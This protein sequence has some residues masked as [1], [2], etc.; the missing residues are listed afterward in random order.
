MNS[1]ESQLIET[2]PKYLSVV[3]ENA[4]KET[5]LAEKEAKITELS[6][7]IA[8]LESNLKTLQKL[9]FGPKSEKRRD[10]SESKQLWLFSEEQLKLPKSDSPAVEVEI[11]V[12]AHKRKARKSFKDNKGNLSHFPEELARKE[13]VLDPEG[14]KSC[15]SCGKD[16]KEI[17]QVVTEKL[18]VVPCQYYVERIIR[19][20]LGCS[21]KNCPPTKAAS[22]EGVLPKSVLGLS[23]IGLSLTQK[24]AWHLPFYRQ[25]QMLAQVGIDVH[26]NMLVYMALKV[27]LE[28]KPI[29]QQMAKEI[30]EAELVHIDETPCIVGIRD[31]DGKKV[32]DRQSYFWPILAN[33]MVVFYYQG[34]RQHCNVKEILG[35]GFKGILMSDGYD[36]YIQYA[37]ERQVT[38]VL[39]W[40]HARRYFVK[41]EKEEPL[42]QEALDKIAHFYRV[43]AE[44]KKKLESH[45]LKPENISQYRKEHTLEQLNAFKD[46]CQKIRDTASVLPKSGLLKAVS[47]VVNHWEWLT[48]YLEHGIV[49]ISNVKV[50][51][52]IR[53][54]KLGAK[55]WLFAASESGADTVA[56]FNSLVCTCKMNNIN[57]LDYL[58]DVLGRLSTDTAKDLT[59]IAW[60][61]ARNV[62]LQL[63]Q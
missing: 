42:A 4:L 38:L 21:C 44:I 1:T 9:L 15:E 8:N 28:L 54:L 20:V 35:D 29:V 62:S 41:I 47:Y 27:G 23:F 16:K 3:N 40:D 2:H 19:P 59:P 52:Q 26:R 34:N 43:E 48:T 56:I 58:T 24:F 30:K 13:T 22:P 61:K 55:N 51:Q 46:W 5:K 12:P 11:E 63:A 25:S 18:Q 31:K 57:V 14:S 7:K 6:K 39:C 49:P 53:N 45:E 50:E 17:S 37:K 10:D 32:Y 60:Q 36:A 33:G